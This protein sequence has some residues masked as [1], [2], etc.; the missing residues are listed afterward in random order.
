MGGKFTSVSTNGGFNVPQVYS[1]ANS[2]NTLISNG[3]ITPQ[4]RLD[5]LYAYGD[6]SWKDMLTLSFSARNDW[7]ST[8]TYPNGTGDY[9]YFYPSVGISWI[10]TDMANDKLG[11]DFL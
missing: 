5:A 1:L 2:K 9:S 4:S 8:L 7:N 6:L 11:S 10:F 3:G